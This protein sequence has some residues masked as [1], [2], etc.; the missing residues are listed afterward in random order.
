MSTGPC[1]VDSGPETGG[2]RSDSAIS[3]AENDVDTTLDFT[4]PS[5]EAASPLEETTVPPTPLINTLP[6]EILV[7]IFEF[8]QYLWRTTS[9]QKEREDSPAVWDRSIRGLMRLGYPE[10]LSHV[11]SL[12]REIALSSSI[13]WTQLE[14]YTLGQS[15]QTFL[16]RCSTFVPR[17]QNRDLHLVV[18]FRHCEGEPL[19]DCDAIKAFCSSVS[20][21]LR[22]LNIDNQALNDTSFATS[23]IKASLPRTTPG[24]LVRLFIKDYGARTIPNQ[25]NNDAGLVGWELPSAEDLGITQDSLDSILRSVRT[26]QLRGQ[27]FPWTSPAYHGLTEL[28]LLCTRPKLGHRPFI[29][30][31]QLREMLLACPELRMLH[32]NINI[33]GQ[34]TS[35][36]LAPVP[37]DKLEELSLRGLPR[38]LYDILIPLL[39]PGPK[40]LQFT[41][42][43]EAE[44]TAPIYCPTILSFFRRTNIT[45]LYLLGRMSFDQCLNV[46]QL[47]TESPTNLRILGLERLRIS[48]PESSQLDDAKALPPMQLSHL[49]LRKC[50]IDID[51]LKKIANLVS[52][53]V[54][55]LHRPEFQSAFSGRETEARQEIASMFPAVKWV[56]STRDMELWNAW[57]LKYID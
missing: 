32:I 2:T 27:F 5:H 16:D 8:A 33:T 23:I 25:T 49:Y 34:D 10:T 17:A 37:L 46:D 13:L 54:V 28:H 22:S 36:A 12:W 29:H 6:T 57:E 51:G 20:P 14:L 9:T 11:C 26:L 18:R 31:S 38:G 52:A 4:P 15:P 39:A 40:P 56:R 43:T 19:S 35:P 3:D 45:S 55:K 48:E 24:T 42:Q 1:S 50:P 30:V 53:Q 7:R 44:T 47:L 41:F 21:R